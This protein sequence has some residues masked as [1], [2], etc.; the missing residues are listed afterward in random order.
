[1][2]SQGKLL[3][4]FMDAFHLSSATFVGHSMGGVVVSCAAV[5]APSK[6][7]A[8]VLIEP[9]FYTKGTPGFLR[10]LFFPLQRIMARQFYSK[11]FMKTFLLN[12]YYDTS[13]VT[14]E[15]VDAYMVPTRTPNALEAM[16]QMLKSVGT[17]QYAGITTRISLP[18]LNVWGKNTRRK[19]AEARLEQARRITREIPGSRLVL[20][21]KSGHYIQEEKPEELA[22]VIGDFLTETESK[23][24]F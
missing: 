3:I 11:S 4:G 9:G 6:V 8:L 20:I 14:D 24:G 10:H 1:M 22:R 19:D 15:V 23:T 21:E 2:E 18:T 5:D 12:S 16:E 13:L 17:E 7:K